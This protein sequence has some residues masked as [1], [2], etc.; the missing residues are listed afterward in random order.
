MSTTGIIALAVVAF[1][2]IAVTFWAY[3]IG[4]RSERLDWV[5]DGLKDASEAVEIDE[6]VARMDEDEVDEHLGRFGRRR[7]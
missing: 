5:E 2:A 4:K 6:E 1:G 3:R 7:L